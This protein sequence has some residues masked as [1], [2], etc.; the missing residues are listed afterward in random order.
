MAN[1]T[2]DYNFTIDGVSSDTHG[3]FVETL[4]P[5]PHAQQRYTTGITSKPYGIPDGVY[6]EISYSIAFHKFYPSDMDDKELRLFLSKGSIL[7]L[8]N[9]PT[10]YFSI[11][12]M[13]T[14]ISQTAD[15][16]RIDYVLSL[17]LEPYRYGVTNPWIN[18]TSGATVKNDG[19]ITS[20]PLIELTDPDGDIV[21]TVNDVDYEIKGLTASETETPN[22]LYIDRERFIIYDQDNML[23]IGKDDG[24]MPEL[25]VG[26]NAI[27]WEGDITAVRIKTNWREI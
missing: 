10:V 2:S 16:K 5:V 25:N 17:T 20:Y 19:T 8:S 7:Q 23:I 11:L 24:K 4:E 13:S 12:T 9:L 14:Q 22:K 3:I 1:Y 27:S 26:N 6:N 18:I 21:L 15:N